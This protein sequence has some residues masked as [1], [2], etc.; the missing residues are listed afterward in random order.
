MSSAPSKRH[1]ELSGELFRQISNNLKGKPCK[2]FSAPFDV[3]LA[4][5]SGPTDDKV[6]SVVQ[7]DLLVVC[8]RSK[9]YERCCNGVP[10]LI[11]EITSTSTG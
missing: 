9:L 11:I 10:D 6:V 4:E 8:D 2:I 3:R 5:R 7:P 1:Q